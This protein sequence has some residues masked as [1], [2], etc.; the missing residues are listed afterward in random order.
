MSI[1]P[2]ENRVVEAENPLRAGLRAGGAQ[3]PLVFVIYGATGDLAQ[4]KLLPALYNLAMRGLL[5]AQFAMI[6]FG[7]TEMDDD[8][9]RNFAQ[10][11][12]RSHSRT[13]LNDQ[14]WPGF[15]RLLHYQTGAFDQREHF[16]ALATRLGRIDE[17]HGTE[18]SRV[19]YFSTPPST[20][21]LILQQ[22]GATGLNQPSGF[23][24]VVIE[25]PF[26][27]DLA[28][29]RELADVAHMAFHERQIFRIDH[30]LGKES[31]QN[32]FVFRFANAIWEPVWSNRFVD[33]VQITVAEELG[34]EHRGRFY[35]ETG[36]VRDIV[37]NHLLQVMALVAM[38]PPARFDADSVRDEKNKVLRATRPLSAECSVRGQYG[39]GHIAGKTVPAYVEEPDVAHD[40]ES[41]TFVASRMEIDNWRW[42]GTPFYIRSGKR[43]PK[44]VTEVA[45]QFKQVPHLPFNFDVAEYLEAD[46]LVLRIQPDEGITL[47]FGAKVPAPTVRVRMVN[48]DFL[49]GSAFLNDL[50][51]AYETLLLDVMRGDGTLFARQDSVERAWQICEPLLAQWET[52]APEVYE[53]GTWGPTAAERLIVEDGRRWRRP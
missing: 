7:R 52:G 19:F 15:A 53:A 28:S 20:F 25:K 43:L 27:H 34:V 41:A 48:M 22:M 45:V 23:A 50:P 26:G 30:Y 8:G 32:I 33:H 17:G 21:P 14:Y 37:Q 13:R 12:I 2:A 38:E 4:R 9:F 47:R 11:A 39:A 3:A 40:S 6:G 36:V 49:Y 29:A 31:V 10:E 18:G 5:P 16:E 46:S 24:R 35:E 1:A 51:E 44:R 42:A